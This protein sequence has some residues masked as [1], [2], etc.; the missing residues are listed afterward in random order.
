MNIV[1]VF[2]FT[3]IL[4]G[5]VDSNIKDEYTR[6]E[7]QKV[8]LRKLQN[9]QQNEVKTVTW[10]EILADVLVTKI[11]NKNENGNEDNKGNVL[12][13]CFS[14]VL[15][16]YK[17]YFYDK[18]FKRANTGSE[19]TDEGEINDDD[20]ATYTPVT[21]EPETKM[22]N[23]KNDVELLEPSYHG[24]I[25]EATESTNTTTAEASR[26]NT[27]C[28]EGTQKDTDGNCVDPQT[29]RFIL[30]I[31]SQCPIGYKK[32]WLGYCREVF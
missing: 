7:T 4:A 6:D 32:D 1:L 27:E 19:V 2:A 31:P 18:L 11:T 21:Q 17:A 26:T 5:K 12:N 3:A 16:L 10:N 14:E 24:K 29:S 22:D 28:P 9:F 15:R 23:P 30:Y 25:E 20:P 8:L 13:K